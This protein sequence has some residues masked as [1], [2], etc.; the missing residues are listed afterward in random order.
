MRVFLITTFAALLLLCSSPKSDDKVKIH[1]YIIELRTDRKWQKTGIIL[2]RKTRVVIEA[3]EGAEGSPEVDEYDPVPYFGHR[4]LILKMGP[5][6]RPFPIGNL[7]SY[8]IIPSIIDEGK[9]LFIGW[10]DRRMEREEIE[11]SKPITVVITVDEN[12]T[13]NNMPAQMAPVNGIWDDNRNPTFVWDSIDNAVRYIYQISEFEDFRIIVRQGEISTA[14]GAGTPSPVVGAETEEIQ[15]T[16]E[17]GIYFWRI[18]A[19]LNLGRPL[20][21]IFCWTDWSPAWRYG[22]EL[23]TPPPPPEF[24]APS[25]DEL[26]QIEIGDCVTIEFIAEDDPSWIF[27]RLRHTVASC[28]EEARIDPNDPEAG[29]PTP[30]HVFQEKLE[31]GDPTKRPKLLAF[32]KYCDIEKGNHLFRVEVRDGMEELTIRTNYTDLKFSVECEEEGEEEGEREE[33]EGTP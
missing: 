33:E 13:C 12:L 3:P 4:G 21:P 29:N 24:I 25:E 6:G 28:D 17:E 20:N 16:L 2:K 1:T 10:N 15:V 9:E 27:W 7:R 30:W 31:G 14:A 11:A 18:R 32:F 22:V 19:Q 23:G 5:E 8:E 26:V